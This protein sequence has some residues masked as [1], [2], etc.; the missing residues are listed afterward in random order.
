[1]DK[2]T[3]FTEVRAEINRRMAFRQLEEILQAAIAADAE[4]ESVRDE[5]EKRRSELGGL[6]DQIRD[7][8]QTAQA[9]ESQA[10]VRIKEANT[11]AEDQIRLATQDKDRI[12][13]QG[14][15]AVEYWEAEVGRARARWEDEVERGEVEIERIQ[16]VRESLQD[17]VRQLREAAARVE[18]GD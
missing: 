1:M 18:K 6:E 13:E 3:A 4:L 15:K 8:N 16:R 10:E 2:Q 17:A 12:I 5:I 11:R 7:A 14:K 9:A